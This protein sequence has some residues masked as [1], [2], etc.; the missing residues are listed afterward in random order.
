MLHPSG[1]APFFSDSAERRFGPHC[2]VSIVVTLD[3]VGSELPSG[4]VQV[5]SQSFPNIVVARKRS[6]IQITARNVTTPALEANVQHSI[7]P[8]SSIPSFCHL[9]FPP[10]DKKN[11][12]RQGTATPDVMYAHYGSSQHHLRHC[13]I[14]PARL[15]AQ[16]K[17][18]GIARSIRE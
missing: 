7:I 4:D 2:D 15:S 5:V 14:D 11:R 8:Y 3:H 18:C 9:S 6:Q 17:P 13:C 12:A 1:Y 16:K 10:Q